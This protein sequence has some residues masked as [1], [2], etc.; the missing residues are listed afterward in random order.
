M[1][2]PEI[3]PPKAHNVYVGTDRY[4]RILQMAIDVSNDTRIQ[5]TPSQFVQHLVDH[6][7][8]IARQNWMQT[9]IAAQ[10]KA[11]LDLTGNPK[12]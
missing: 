5:I 1:E 3:K 9:L 8:E 7:S 10:Q 2:T 6:Y 11:Q 4:D 12:F